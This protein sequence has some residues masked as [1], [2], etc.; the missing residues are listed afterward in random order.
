MRYTRWEA[1]GKED[2][3]WTE[4]DWLTGVG[5]R[6]ALVETEIVRSIKVD[7]RG[8][9]VRSCG[10]ASASGWLMGDR[11]GWGGDRDVVADYGVNV[12]RRSA[13]FRFV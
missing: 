11:I 5:G 7:A 8:R 12:G 4:V 6:L 10:W 9:L 1:G 13:S 2:W 3:E